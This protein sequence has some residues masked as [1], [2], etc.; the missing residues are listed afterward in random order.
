[1]S[2]ADRGELTLV[3]HTHMPYVEGY[4]TW[5]FGEEWLWEAIATC[6]LPLAEL[7]D[8]QAPAPLTLSVTPVLADQ[9]QAPGVAA[10]F[11]GFLRDVRRET[12]RRDAEGCRA[13]GEET[14]ARELERAAGD[15]ER[16]LA[17][18]ERLGSLGDDL[19]APLA[20]HAS[21]TSSATHAVLPLV[22]TDAG[23]RLQVESGIAAH[24][25]RFGDWAGGFWLP[26][27][28]YAPWLDPLLEAAGVHATCVDLTDVLGL[29]DPRQ[30]TPLQSDE[31]PLLVP[32]DRA[33]IE[34]VWSDGGYPA[35]GA[36][37]DYHHHTTYHHRVWRNDGGL[38]D[39]DAALAQARA[40]AAEFVA[41]AIA[42]LDAGAAALGCPAL[43]VCALDTELLG[44][45]WYEGV[46]WLGAVLEEAERQG[47]ALA[48]LDDALT[49]HEAVPVPAG[50]LPVTSWGSGRDLSTWDG[51]RVADLA[52]RA[53]AAE[54]RAFGGGRTP[55][56]RAARELLALQSSDWAFQ[57][58]RDSAGDYPR[59]RAAGHAAALEA[60]L[61]G[62]PDTVARD[63]GTVRGLAPWLAL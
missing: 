34:L 50:G 62:P 45:W 63:D 37:R 53:R 54:L 2:R 17:T 25:A 28:A 9:L 5:P 40:H 22:M 39:H 3:L 52:W 33:T 41:A 15:Y 44:H 29:G 47:L 19:L 49:R 58:S 23:L 51:P 57:V 14:M 32:L 12:H 8:A 21:W 59:E 43:A 20:P 4:G 46:A 48:S 30:L 27:C 36:Y 56:P 60:A 24:R 13:G 31:G 35:H 10:R 11:A 26:E 6:Y 61:S 18:V 16:A 1:M 55:R 42:R 38:Y 7:L